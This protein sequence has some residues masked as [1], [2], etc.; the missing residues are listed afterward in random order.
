MSGS[1]NLALS[2]SIIMKLL[3][4][5]IKLIIGICLSLKVKN[6]KCGIQTYIK[7]TRKPIFLTP[8]AKEIFNQLRQV[9]IK[10]LILQYF[11]PKCYIWIE[12]NISGYTMRRVLRQLTIDY[13]TFDQGHWYQIAY[14]SR[15]MVLVEMRYKIHN[16]KLL[17]IVE[18][19]KTWR[20][21]L[22]DCKYIFLVLTN[23]NNLCYFL[24]TK[25]LSSC[26]V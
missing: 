25:S 16:G 11:D 19:F 18:V 20:H 23:N 1:L 9:F 6:A 12:I 5:M 17:A 10:A 22:K 13:L 4:I 7:V 8:G 24:K 15:K 21:Y 3:E 14:F 26:P 2:E